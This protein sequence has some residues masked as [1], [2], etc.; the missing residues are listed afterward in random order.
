MTRPPVP[1]EASAALAREQV[2]LS[3][4]THSVGV[5]AV[6]SCETRVL[7]RLATP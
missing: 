4:P 1:D 5:T 6:S 2:P 7:H 3:R